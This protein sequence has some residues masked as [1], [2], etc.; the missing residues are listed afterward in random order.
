M[1]LPRSVVILALSVPAVS[2]VVAADD[3]LER[4]SNIA[5][6][7]F[8]PIERTLDRAPFLHDKVLTVTEDSL[9]S[10]WV[11]NR[12]CHRH[13]SVTPAL[14]IV[15]PEGKIRNITIGDASNVGAVEVRGHTIHLEDVNE[16]STLCINSENLLLQREAD[17]VY[18][19]T[20]GPFFYRFMDG[21]FPLEVR[22]R[23]QYPPTL[24]AV[25]HVAPGDRRGVEVTRNF[26][27]VSLWSLFEGTLWVRMLFRRK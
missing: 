11:H 9:V 25:T 20:A 22:L 6:E 1:L 27:E 17:G 21:Y 8:S 3:D 2:A 16:H 26:G 15:F 12:Q 23:V 24:L 18:R 13:F 5:D 10:G 19:M 14:D 7:Q 4:L